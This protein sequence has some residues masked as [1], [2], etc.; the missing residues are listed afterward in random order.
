MVQVGV[1]GMYVGVVGWFPGASEPLLYQ[2]VPLD[3]RFADSE[4]LKQVF[5]Q[6]QQ[7]LQTLG[8][9]GLEIS[10][11]AHPSGQTYVG[12]EACGE[13]HTTAY[14][15]W[16][17]GVDGSGGPHF[18]ATDSLVNPGE[19]TWVQRHYDPEC[20]SCHVTGWNPQR[21]FPYEGGFVALESS[22][23]LHGNGCENCHGPGSRHVAAENGDLDVSENELKSL[24]KSMQV[25][26]EATQC[27][28]CHDLDNSPDFH[29]D[30]AFEK[31]WARIVHEGKD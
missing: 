7:Q 6:Y 29:V 12:S 16:K 5:Q 23:A 2:R 20:L 21:Y 25:K 13:C 8:L 17:N 19:R 9:S 28:E 24:Q 3:A 30:G 11:V 27:M 31:Y 22:A 26:L 10:P 1:K 15:I 14:E 4:E 18:G